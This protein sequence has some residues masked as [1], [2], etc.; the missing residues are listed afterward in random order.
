MA[1]TLTINGDFHLS[2]NPV[3]VE[4]SGAA[5]PAGSSEYRV[6]LKITSVD[7]DL[8]GAPFVDAIAPDSDGKALFE[9]SGYVNQP[10]L[11]TF[12]W[13]LAGGINPY[14]DMLFD[15]KLTPGE[16][17]IDSQGDLQEIWG[18]ESDSKFVING[19]LE[20]SVLASFN[21]EGTSFY[22]QYVVPV[23]FLT[24]QPDFQVVSPFQPV[25]YWVLAPEQQT[26]EYRT[27]AYYDDG[28]TYEDSKPGHVLYKFIIHEIN[29]FPPHNHSV[30]MPMVKASG[31]KMTH[32]ESWLVGK[33]QK[34]TC[35]VDHSFYEHNNYLF[36]V[37]RLGGIDVVWLH[38]GAQTG[39]KTTQVQA[40]KPILKGASRFDRS[41][42]TSR[43]TRRT[44]SIN[45]GFKSKAEM[46]AL[47]GLMQSDQVWLLYGGHPL[48]QARLYPVTIENSEDIL[49]HWNEDL[50]SIDIEMTEAY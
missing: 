36:F 31:A 48:S 13:P 5:A 39:H 34:R 12:E 14:G 19:A 28:S 46:A 30:N 35:V 15:I 38:G 32:Y 24:L 29:A 9:I 33:T 37:N 50:E 49:V 42:V 45:S 41:V 21:A 26:V 40:R 7:G 4:V 27:K 22:H 8:I 16:L 43:Q 44:F 3:Y 1:L 6:L 11:R 25:K 20:P 18:S 47:I 23:R 2:G 10:A 17:Y